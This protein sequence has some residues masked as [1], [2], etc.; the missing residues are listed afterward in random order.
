MVVMS[1]II[2]A[3]ISILAGILVLIFPKLLSRIV[4]IYLIVVGILQLLGT[5]ISFSP[6]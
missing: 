6:Y 1:T 4:A 5:Y 3:I 2:L